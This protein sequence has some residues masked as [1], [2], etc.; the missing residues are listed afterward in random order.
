MFR[1]SDHPS[2]CSLA[3][4]GEA[5]EE[6]P[7]KE[8]AATDLDQD[9]GPERCVGFPDRARPRASESIFSAAY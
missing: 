1:T 4:V 9:D 8:G 6:N 2:S 5:E 7:A 3:L